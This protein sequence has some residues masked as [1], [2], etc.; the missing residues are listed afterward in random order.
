MLYRVN[1]RFQ[2]DIRGLKDIQGALSPSPA[3]ATNPKFESTTQVERPSLTI[4]TGVSGS[5]I[6]TSNLTPRNLRVRLNSLVSNAQRPQKAASSSTLTVQDLRQQSVP[7]CPQSPLSE[8]SDNLSEDDEAA[9]KEEEAERRA[10]E[11]EALNLKLEQLSR[12]ITNDTLGI[13]RSKRDIERGN[14]DISPISTNPNSATN[15][16]RGDSLSSRSD[17]QSLSSTSSPQGSIADVPSPATD[18]QPQ[19]PMHFGHRRSNTSS[20]SPVPVSSR[21]A[22]SHS[23]NRRY[24]Q[25]TG[26]HGSGHSETSSFSDLSGK[27]ASLWWRFSYINWQP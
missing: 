8:D 6:S 21:S 3:I 17:N 23:H 15:S 18:S 10:E 7:L 9:L 12:L 16:F 4:Q 24:S 5:G 26:D 22:M 11:Q 13:I 20:V 27:S 19:S 1:A 2:Q 25:L 14:G